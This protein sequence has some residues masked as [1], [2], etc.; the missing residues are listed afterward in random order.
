VPKGKV[1]KEKEIVIAR[2]KVKELVE[3]LSRIE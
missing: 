1:F 3:I 2:E